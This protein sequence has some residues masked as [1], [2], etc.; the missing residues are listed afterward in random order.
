V[1]VSAAWDALLEKALAKAGAK[2]LRGWL[3]GLSAPEVPLSQLALFRL[4]SI[5]DLVIRQYFAAAQQ[6]LAAH[7]FDGARATYK[8]LIAE[9]SGSATA[10]RAQ[11]LLEG[12]KPQAIAYYAA[13][14]RKQFQPQAAGQFGKPQDKA[15]AAFAR[16]YAETK[17]DPALKLQANEA[18]LSWSQAQMTQGKW[19]EATAHLRTLQA[20]YLGD[21]DAATAQFL[22]GFIEG[23]NAVRKYDAAVAL[24]ERVWSA[25]PRSSQAPEALWHAA[26]YRAQQGKYTDGVLLLSKLQKEYPS[27][28][29]TK[30][31]AAWIETFGQRAH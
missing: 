13:E 2:A 19:V 22:L 15:A 30:Y 24:L 17:D 11:A 26:F 20:A 28:P 29:R 7:N 5:D 1:L 27:S 4:Q 21:E 25:H 23:S 12:V 31:A 14:G 6:Q 16:L 9:Y 8:T 10:E 18:L 3:R